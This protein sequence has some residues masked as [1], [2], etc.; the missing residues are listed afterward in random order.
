MPSHTP[1]LNSNAIL[2]LLLLRMT[3]ED[4]AYEDEVDRLQLM[5]DRKARA[6]RKAKGGYRNSIDQHDCFCCYYCY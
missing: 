3:V 1:N 2:I 6:E 5:K 4:E